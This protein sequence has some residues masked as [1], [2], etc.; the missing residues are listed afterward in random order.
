MKIFKVIRKALLQHRVDKYTLKSQDFYS[1]SERFRGL[2]ED[3]KKQVSD[4]SIDYSVGLRD[5]I[6]KYNVSSTEYFNKSDHCEHLAEIYE[7]K[8][9]DLEKKLK[10][11]YKD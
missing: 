8:K 11:Y 10:F 5:V 4:L 7:N 1:K 6:E 3:Y 9:L 2:A